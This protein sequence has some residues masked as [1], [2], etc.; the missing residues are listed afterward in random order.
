MMKYRSFMEGF[1]QKKL[2]FMV[3]RRYFIVAVTFLILL[4]TVLLFQN[5][6]PIKIEA[7]ASQLAFSPD[8]KFLAAAG[9]KGVRIWNVSTQKLIS[10]FEETSSEPNQTSATTTI[11]FSP[12]G[13]LLAADGHGG[14]VNIW[15]VKDGSLLYTLPGHSAVVKSLAFS[16]DGTLLAT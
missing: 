11:A 13:Q 3:H 14:T 6:Q 2:V 8:G 10:T 7:N 16:P 9:R 12:D 4:I 1:K 5:N 15:R